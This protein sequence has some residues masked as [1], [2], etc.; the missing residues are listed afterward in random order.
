MFK[1]VQTGRMPHMQ[2]AIP[3]DDRR[4]RHWQEVA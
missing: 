3:C 4:D 1:E 2:Q